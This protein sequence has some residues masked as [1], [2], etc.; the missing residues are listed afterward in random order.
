MLRT[1]IQ[2]LN[3]FLPG[4]IYG[5]KICIETVQL[6][7]Y[8]LRS[9]G[10]FIFIILI[11]IHSFILFFHIKRANSLFMLSDFHSQPATVNFLPFFE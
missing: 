1:T 8:L 6:H 9:K 2:S 11:I 3:L 4:L 7:S 10:A 5:P